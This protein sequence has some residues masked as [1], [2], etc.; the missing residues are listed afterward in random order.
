M[1]DS[2]GGANR[3]MAHNL[4]SVRLH[5]ER[6]S[7]DIGERPRRPD[8]PNAYAAAL[9]RSSSVGAPWYVVPANRKWYR[10]WAASQLLIETIEEMKLIYP[11]P[12]LD[13]DAQKR[14][15]QE[16]A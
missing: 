2:K 10:N 7:R 14:A 8:Y 12:H 16:V 5:R 1:A 15:S 11:N 4:L 13:V 6:V 9:A 3:S